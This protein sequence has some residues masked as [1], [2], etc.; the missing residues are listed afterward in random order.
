MI[1]ITTTT[2]NEAQA[3]ISFPDEYVKSYLISRDYQIRVKHIDIP[4]KFHHNQIEVQTIE[5][6]IAIRHGKEYGIK[7]AFEHSLSQER[8]YLFVLMELF[9]LTDRMN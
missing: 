9:R 1:T 7:A 2:R 8:H 5:V 6:D 4:R 3:I